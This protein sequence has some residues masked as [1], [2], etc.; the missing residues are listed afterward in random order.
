MPAYNVS[1][2]DENG[3][4]EGH[5]KNG[6]DF[7]VISTQL[8]DVARESLDARGAA[9]LFKLSARLVAKHAIVNNVSEH[10]EA[11]AQLLGLL[12]FILEE[13]DTRGWGTLPANLTL[14]RIPLPPGTHNIVVTANSV[15]KEV[16]SVDNIRIAAGQRIYRKIRY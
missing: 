6:A 1:V 15:N 5:R 7:S 2:I 8:G 11:A 9:L 4:D 12:F 16:F 10:D 3:R 13:A 14:L